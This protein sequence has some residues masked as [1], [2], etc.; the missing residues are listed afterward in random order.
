MLLEKFYE[1]IG[2]LYAAFIGNA[3]NL[4][5]GGIEQEHGMFY[6]LA[7]DEFRQSTVHFAPEQR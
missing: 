5:V 7:V 3:L 1:I 4:M 6:A 2:V